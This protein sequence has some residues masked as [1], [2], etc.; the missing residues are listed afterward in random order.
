MRRIARC[1]RFYLLVRSSYLIKGGARC[2]C[3]FFSGLGGW[4]AS[5]PDKRQPMMLHHEFTWLVSCINGRIFVNNEH[6]TV[7]KFQENKAS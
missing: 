1:G 4:H 2:Q 7:C 5:S 6:M 3:D